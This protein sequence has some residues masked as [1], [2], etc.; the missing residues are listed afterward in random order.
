MESKGAPA[1]VLLTG[2]RTMIFG[3]S[4]SPMRDVLDEVDEAARLGFD[5]VEL[6][7]DAVGLYEADHE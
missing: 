5:Y 3:M 2:A 4:N 7:M 1:L 6:N